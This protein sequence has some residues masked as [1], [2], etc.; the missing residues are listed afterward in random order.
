M[1]SNLY[2]DDSLNA[3]PLQLN[4]TDSAADPSLTHCQVKCELS[5]GPFACGLVLDSLN[6]AE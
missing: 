6:T 5:K 1:Y 2:M 4:T 3:P